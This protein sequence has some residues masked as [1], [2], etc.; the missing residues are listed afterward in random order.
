LP[1]DVRLDASTSLA[2]LAPAPTRI[3]LE[4]SRRS[5]L[6][7]AGRTWSSSPPRLLALIAWDA[8]GLDLPISRLFGDAS[9]FL[10]RPVARLRRAA[11]G[12]PLCRV[13]ARDRARDRDLAALPFARALTRGER[14]AWVVATIGCALLI[15]LLKLASLTSCPWSLAE[16]GGTAVHVSHWALGVPTA[17]PGAA[18]RRPRD[19]GLLLPARVVRPRR[20]APLAAGA[21]SSRRS[22]PAPC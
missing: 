6:G 21:G 1:D 11:L 17:A 20:A 4:R 5:T 8:P 14:I 3:D 15:P 18:F 9:A 2:S 13:G 22:S 19:R 10:A 16:F 7:R 12:C